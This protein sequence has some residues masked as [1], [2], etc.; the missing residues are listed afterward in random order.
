[1]GNAA[2][3]ARSGRY[4]TEGAVAQALRSAFDL[5]GYEGVNLFPSLAGVGAAQ[6]IETLRVEADERPFVAGN[7][8]AFGNG[9][10]EIAPSRAKTRRSRR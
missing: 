4:E 6:D 3:W 9:G 1:M 10:G 2:T 8:L 7:H 5:G